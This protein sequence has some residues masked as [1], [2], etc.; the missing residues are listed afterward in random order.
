MKIKSLELFIKQKKIEI[1]RLSARI[2]PLKMEMEKLQEQLHRNEKRIRAM[3]E[4]PAQQLFDLALAHSHLSDLRLQ[5][6]KILVTIEQLQK[7]ILAL[8]KELSQLFGQK[9]GLEKLLERTK[10]ERI[11]KAN[12]EENRLAD[13]SYLRKI[14]TP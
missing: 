8:Q 4:R 5:N 14:H 1:E 10:K 7:D 6:E 9:K 11:K 13:E 2:M 12:E 3:E